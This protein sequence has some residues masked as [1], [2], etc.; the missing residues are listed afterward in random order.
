MAMTLHFSRSFFRAVGLCSVLSAGTTLLLIFLPQ[1]YEI[2]GTV[3]EQAALHANAFYMAR[4]WVYFLHP[5]LVLTAAWGVAA[6]KLNTAAGAATTGSLFFAVWGFTEALQQALS[7]VALNF[8]WRTGYT[9]STDEALR[10]ML[11][12]QR[13]VLFGS[14]TNPSV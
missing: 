11:H 7:L 8:T 1:L 4:L 3:E 6:K 12:T 10:Q 14:A 5:F 9:E 13:A 2:P